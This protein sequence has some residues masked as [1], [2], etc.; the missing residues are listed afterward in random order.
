ML[1]YCYLLSTPPIRL[2][3]FILI[4]PY[5]NLIL[6]LFIC[7]FFPLDYLVL[8]ELFLIT[9]IRFTVPYSN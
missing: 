2:T 4:S 3:C 5:F 1:A 8:S 9:G 7:F 6:F